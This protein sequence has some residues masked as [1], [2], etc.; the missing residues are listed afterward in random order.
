MTAGDAGCAA[1]LMERQR[2]VYAGYSPVFWRPAEGAAGLHERFLR[3]Q[4][5]SA[6]TVALRTRHGFIIC[7]RRRPE[8]LVD[9]FTVAPPGTWETDGAALL[10]TAAGRLAAD[11]ISTVRV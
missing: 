3:R 5:L 11:G 9:E 7:E 1:A 2:Q 10:L 8:A 6:A 4:V